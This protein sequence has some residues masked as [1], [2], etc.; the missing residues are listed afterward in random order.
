MNNVFTFTSA[1]KKYVPPPRQEITNFV[2][3]EF[4]YIAYS[5]F[6]SPNNHVFLPNAEIGLSGN[7]ANDGS[8]K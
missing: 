7:T 8:Y 6:E 5:L 3:K 4:S 1:K 2:G